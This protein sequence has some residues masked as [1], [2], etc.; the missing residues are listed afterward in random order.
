MVHSL[1]RPDTQVVFINFCGDK[2][3]NARK[4][5]AGLPFEAYER[6]KTDEIRHELQISRERSHI[7]SAFSGHADQETIVGHVIKACKK[8]TKILI[9]HSSDPSRKELKRAFLRESHHTVDVVLPRLG[10]E[11]VV[12]KIPTKQ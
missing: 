12:K 9:N 2:D 5:L 7:I 11:Y 3:S 10:G 6:D 4:L 1:K 8:G